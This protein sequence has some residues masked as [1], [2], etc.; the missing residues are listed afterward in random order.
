MSIAASIELAVDISG[1]VEVCEVCDVALVS[2]H[3]ATC[4]HCSGGKRPAFLRES[5]HEHRM[6]LE[7]G[8]SETLRRWHASFLAEH[9]FTDD[10][11]ADAIETLPP[12]TDRKAQALT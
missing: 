7:D 5:I 9:V 4:E 12:W 11:I 6:A 2:I 1:L 3:C 10:E 8:D